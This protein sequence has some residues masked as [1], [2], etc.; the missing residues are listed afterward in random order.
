MCALEGSR[1]GAQHPV[2]NLPLVRGRLQSEWLRASVYTFGAF[3]KNGPTA[4][5]A[6]SELT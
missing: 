4:P 1:F 6:E 3:R 5:N 2:V